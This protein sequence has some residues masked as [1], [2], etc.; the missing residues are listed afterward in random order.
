MA[1]QQYLAQKAPNQGVLLKIYI[2]FDL[3]NG[4][5]GGELLAQVHG[6]SGMGLGARGVN[7]ISPIKSRIPSPRAVTLNSVHL[8][9]TAFRV[10][11]SD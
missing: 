10:H 6:D 9:V 8:A 2:F 4:I 3:S 7:Y 1:K 5:D 11:F